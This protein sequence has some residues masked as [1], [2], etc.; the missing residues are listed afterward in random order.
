VEQT[1]AR[2]QFVPND[3]CLDV[4]GQRLMVITGP[5]MAGKST[6]MRQVALA[7][8]LAQAGGFVPASEARIGVVDK[9]YTRVGASDA[10]ARGQSTFM[11]EMRESSNILRGAT[12]RSLVILDEIGRGT[13]TYDGLAIAWA[14][15]EHLH[16]MIGCRTMFATHYHELCELAAT[17][18]GVVNFNVAAKEYKDEV[19]FLHKLVPG[20]A[21]RSYGV[22]VA[23][24]AGI[25]AIVLARAKAILKELETGAAL[26]SGAPS[27]LRKKNALGAVQ[28]DM[29][30]APPQQPPPSKV[31]ATLRELS[32]DQ[33][34]P[35]DAL[36]ALAKLKAML[37]EKD[38]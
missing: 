27:S 37:T 6:T 29:F 31:E 23:S 2:G 14:V 5:N 17:R 33:M 12:R 19:V 3:I 32:V 24:L 21:N 22:A 34:T 1:V 18:A 13:S 25:P 35:I 26:P 8:I 36:L 9:I 20:G 15:S 16:D 11:V 10:L 4:E 7:V 30:S 28:L 38:Q